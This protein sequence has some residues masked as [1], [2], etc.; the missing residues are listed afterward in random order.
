VG[1]PLCKLL[2]PGAIWGKK[3]T[4]MHFE[5]PLGELTALFPDPLPGLRGLLLW[6]D[7]FEGNEER[8]G[9]K[10]EG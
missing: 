5:T 2:P 10:G 8:T 6:E 9:R 4:K 7:L 1:D 3:C